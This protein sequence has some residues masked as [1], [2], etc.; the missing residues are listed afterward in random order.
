MASVF[1]YFWSALRAK[2]ASVAEVGPPVVSRPSRGHISKSKQDRPVVTM[3][4]YKEVG[5][6]D[7]VA[8]SRSFR[9]RRNDL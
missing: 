9:R 3:E 5:I 4:R 8:A 7:S 1:V 6:A 2:Y